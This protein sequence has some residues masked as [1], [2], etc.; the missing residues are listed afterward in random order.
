MV[1]LRLGRKKQGKGRGSSEVNTG[2]EIVNLGESA[3]GGRL[4]TLGDG[5]G[6]LGWTSIGGAGS[7]A[8]GS[9]AVGG[10]AVTLEKM[11]ESACMETN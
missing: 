11:R 2:G 5:A 4:G 7:G 9:G 6:K 1:L 3:I 8:I 10:V